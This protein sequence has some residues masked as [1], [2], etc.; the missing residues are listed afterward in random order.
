MLSP[1]FKG[2]S[3]FAKAMEA[4]LEGPGPSP[5]PSGVID[6]F[7]FFWA[8]LEHLAPRCSPA[9]PRAVLRA[10]LASPDRARR[11]NGNPHVKTMTRIDALESVVH[12]HYPTLR[13]APFPGLGLG[14][15]G[16]GGNSG[17]ES[18]GGESAPA[19]PRRVWAGGVVAEVPRGESLRPAHPDASEGARY[20]EAAL[21]HLHTRSLGDLVGKAIGTRLG[22]KMLSAAGGEALRGL[23]LEAE[24][25]GAAPVLQRFIAAVGRKVT[26]AFKNKSDLFWFQCVQEGVRAD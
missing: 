6:A 18:G 25:G 12:P 19:V 21:V 5:S 3:D 9:S 11:L 16:G 13:R 23:A 2:V 20:A 4:R 15:R 17:S 8:S 22:D 26:V 14:A 1:N 24:A 10:A 7:Q